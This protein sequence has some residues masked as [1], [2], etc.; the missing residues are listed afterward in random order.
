[1]ISF[2]LTSS[3]H[4]DD[5]PRRRPK[6]HR[7][8][9]GSGALGRGNDTIVAAEAPT[10]FGVGGATRRSPRDGH[11]EA[12]GYNSAALLHTSGQFKLHDDL[13]KYLYDKGKGCAAKWDETGEILYVRGLINTTRRRSDPHMPSWSAQDT[14]IG[15][16]S[17]SNPSCSRRS[18]VRLRFLRPHPTCSPA[19][20]QTSPA[21][22]MDR[23]LGHNR[24]AHAGNADGPRDQAW[25]LPPG[26]PR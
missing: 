26:R 3:P 22:H 10:S 25:S 5:R 13:K 16:S 24:T 20:C 9:D 1:M 18:A 14:L 6:I 19:S 8:S 7:P 17:F 15:C 11:P 4:L 21:S 12:I 23:R 2:T